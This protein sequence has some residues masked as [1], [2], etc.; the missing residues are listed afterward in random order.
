M[1]ELLLQLAKCTQGTWHV[2]RW[3]PSEILG[4]DH[5]YQVLRKR[6]SPRKKAD[7]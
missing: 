7:H 4:K 1:G 3:L 5:A 2:G 6:Q